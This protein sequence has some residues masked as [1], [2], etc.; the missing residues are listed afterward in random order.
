[1]TKDFLLESGALDRSAILTAHR[2]RSNVCCLVTV[3][4]R[5]LVMCSSQFTD[6]KTAL[7]GTRLTLIPIS[8]P[9]EY[10]LKENGTSVFIV[11]FLLVHA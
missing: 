6:R 3:K 5:P 2:L 4:P 9:Y 7:G 11:R 8:L 1:M 10:R